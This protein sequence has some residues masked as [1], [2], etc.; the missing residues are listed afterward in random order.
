[1]KVYRHR[2]GT[3]LNWYVDSINGDDGNLGSSPGQAFQTIAALLNDYAAGQSVGL[4]RGS[5][6]HEELLIP[7]DNCRVRAFGTGTTPILDASDVIT[8]F[9]KTGGRTNVYEKAIATAPANGEQ[10][11]NAWEDGVA[12]LRASSVAN[13]DATPGSHY[14][15]AETGNITWYVHPTGSGNPGTNS[16]TY[17]VSVRDTGLDAGSCSYVSVSDLVVQKQQNACG[18]IRVGR[19][20]TLTNVDSYDGNKHNVYVQ[21]GCTLN[22]VHAARA[23]HHSQTRSC[24]VFNENTPVGLGVTFNNC[25][26]DDTGTLSLYGTSAFYGHYNTSGSFGKVVWNDCIAIACFEGFTAFHSD[27]F[28][29][30]RCTTIDCYYAASPGVNTTF[31]DCNFA[32]T[33]FIAP[34]NIDNLTYTFN[35]GLLTIA[36][37]NK[38]M[39]NNAAARVGSVLI[40]NGVTIDH[41][42]TGAFLSDYSAAGLTINVTNCIFLYHDTDLWIYYCPGAAQTITSDYNIYGGP[43]TA[44][45]SNDGAETLNGPAWIAAGYDTH[46][47]FR[48]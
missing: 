42:G 44:Y 37:A 10:Y 17:E 39:I 1:M 12:M 46:S 20:S 32:A 23:Y 6:W 21:D 9:S 36:G 45:Y 43:E 25:V 16:K 27:E 5:H 22:N 41:Q 34:F 3:K 19:S 38:F 11:I 13:C 40:M 14:P 31:N 18:A 26:A 33:A 4:A 7:G 29:V 35:G 48:L 24:F 2:H 30:N 47:V 8:G 15:T 28:I